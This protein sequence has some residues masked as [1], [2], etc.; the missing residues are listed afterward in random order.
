MTSFLSRFSY[1]VTYESIS[2]YGLH[3]IHFFLKPSY[4]QLSALAKLQ[5]NPLLFDFNIEQRVADFIRA[6]MNQ[7]NL[8]CY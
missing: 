3:T 7:V 5:D 2:L 1:Y 4:D 6:A 8:F